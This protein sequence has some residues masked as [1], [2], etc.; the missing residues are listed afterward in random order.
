MGKHFKYSSKRQLWRLLI[1]DYDKII[2]ESRDVSSKEVFFDCYDLN[3]TK[4]VFKNF[5]LEEKYWLGIESVYKDIIYFHRFPKPDMPQH[6]EIIAVDINS[7]NN[8][9]NN[10]TL[11]FHFVAE[12]IVYAYTQGFEDR[13]YFAL[14]YL[15]GE[16]IENIGPD[17]EK[18]NSLRSELD[19]SEKWNNYYYPEKLN[20]NSDSAILSMV[21]SKTHKYQIAGD[22]E[23][24]DFNNKFLFSFNYLVKESIYSNVFFALDKVS[25]KELLKI[26]LNENVSSLFNDSFFIYKDFL[27]LLK[28]KS[29]LIIYKI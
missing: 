13:D 6:K 24:I 12:D 5:Q 4:T 19:K 10:S 17:Y 27:F 16:I 21:E 28:E 22:I 7:Q 11:T 29:G 2:I 25:G 20:Q 23:T 18:I 8:L 1:S 3:S 14:N 15:S 9:W 26:E